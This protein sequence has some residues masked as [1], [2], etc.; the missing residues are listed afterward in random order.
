MINLKPSDLPSVFMNNLKAARKLRGMSQLALAEKLHMG[1][2]SVNRWENG[3]QSPTLDTVVK[4]A[5]ALN[6]S[7]EALLSEIGSEIFSTTST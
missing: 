5:E 3:V 7:P 6:V 2:V 1:Y 4:I